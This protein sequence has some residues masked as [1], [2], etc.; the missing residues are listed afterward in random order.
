[1][2]AL[3]G[4]RS[5]ALAGYR[6]VVD[7]WFR[8]GDWANQWLSLRY[9]FAILETLEHD[10]MAATLYGALDA[11]GVMRALPLE[12]G[13][14]DEFARAVERLST[15]LGAERFAQSAARGRSMRDEEV[16]RHTLDTIERVHQPPET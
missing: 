16:V 2:R 5:D 7:T 3:Q 11:A 8:G 14:A 10:E 13:N 9:V 4:N 6:Y 1:M 15:R 12:P